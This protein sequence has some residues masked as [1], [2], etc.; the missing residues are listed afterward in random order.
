MYLYTSSL[1]YFDDIAAAIGDWIITKFD[2]RR[3]GTTYESAQRYFS[4]NCFN[5][6][7]PNQSSCNK[8]NDIYWML[9][10]LVV[11]IGYLLVILQSHIQQ[12][13]KP[14]K[15]RHTNIINL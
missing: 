12:Y 5:Q 7:H 9:C 6:S 10:A 2:D 14:K 1:G 15:S 13:N 8:G 11:T 4:S 3:V